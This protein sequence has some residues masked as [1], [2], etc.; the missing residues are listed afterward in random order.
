MIAAAL[1]GEAAVGA[2]WSHDGDLRA[3]VRHL[4]RR[5]RKLV[6]GGY[7]TLLGDGGD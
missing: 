4:I 2:R 3:Q 7:R 6:D 1:F 5:G